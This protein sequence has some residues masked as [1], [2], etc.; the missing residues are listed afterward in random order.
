[1]YMPDAIRGTIQLGE[2]DFSKLK[3]HSN[4][5]FAAISFSCEELVNEI[6]KHIP[7]FKVEYKPD[8]RQAIADSWPRSIDDMAAREQ[9]NWK[10]EYNLA[11]MTD[12]MLKNLRVKLEAK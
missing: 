1:M 4:F 7:D 9:W 8:F 12:E 11:K 6:K 2:A 10:P 5:N 3:Q